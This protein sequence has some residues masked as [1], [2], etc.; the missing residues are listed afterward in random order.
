MKRVETA[1]SLL[2]A[3]AT[4]GSACSLTGPSEGGGGWGSWDYLPK[5][6]GFGPPVSGLDFVGGQANTVVLRV[7]E[8][9][10]VVLVVNK[11]QQVVVSKDCPDRVQ[12]AAFREIQWSVPDSGTIHIDPP[13]GVRILSLDPPR[14]GEVGGWA[15]DP[16][17]NVT[18]L[19]RGLQPGRAS[20]WISAY[21]GPGKTG[22][23]ALAGLSFSVI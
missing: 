15:A 18:F 10:T 16:E 3:L 11:P 19:V 23:W 6:G 13:S 12:T 20:L 4:L 21:L 14:A 22:E 7:G 1:S 17:G 5:C 2:L 9:R 8:E